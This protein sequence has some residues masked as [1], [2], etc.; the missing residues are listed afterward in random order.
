MSIIRCLRTFRLPER[1]SLIWLEVETSDGLVGLGETFR[2]AAAVETCLHDEL[3]PWLLGRDA[4]HIEGISRHLLTPYVGYNGSGVEVRSASAVD[5]ALWDL[6]GQRQGVPVHEALGGAA[7]ESIP[8]YNT[9]AGSAY[10]TTS[11]RRDIGAGDSA[12]GPYD[13]QVSFMRDAGA[14]ARSLLD[15]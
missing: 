14:L 8:V 7:R 4:R 9:C 10:N 2:G 11:Q 15:E 5:I 6:A 12:Q 1:P 3:A 13:D